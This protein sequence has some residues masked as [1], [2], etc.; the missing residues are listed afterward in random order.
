VMVAA[1]ERFGYTLIEVPTLDVEQRVQFILES[2]KGGPM[3][4]Q[5][6]RVQFG[7]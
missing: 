6:Y 1:Y 7:C 3:I 2:L 4:G 5:Y